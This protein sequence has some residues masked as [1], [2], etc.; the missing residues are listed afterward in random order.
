[1]QLLRH[2]TKPR[3]VHAASACTDV[4]DTKLLC[5]YTPAIQ[6]VFL[7]SVVR[8]HMPLAVQH[9]A[10]IARPS[11]AVVLVGELMHTPETGLSLLPNRAITGLKRDGGEGGGGEGLGGGGDGECLGCSAAGGDGFR[12]GEN[13]VGGAGRGGGGAGLGGDGTGGAGD[14]DGGGRDGVGDGDDGGGGDG[15]RRHCPHPEQTCC[16]VKPISSSTAQRS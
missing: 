13:G 8:L 9:W 5:P 6:P 11:G 3:D 14:G 15:A 2:S 16:A 4:I 12:G 10:A 1:M 7:P